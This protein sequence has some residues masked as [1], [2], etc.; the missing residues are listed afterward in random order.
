VTSILLPPGNFDAFRTPAP[1]GGEGGPAKPPPLTHLLADSPFRP[2]NWRWEKARALQAA[3]RRPDRRYDDAHIA[4]ALAFLG[5]RAK[6]GDEWAELEFLRRHEPVYLAARY[7]A[8]AD[9][10]DRVVRDALE[11]RLLAAN[12]T[13]EAIAKVLRCPLE[14]VRWYERL[15]FNVRDR[16]EARDWLM[17]YALGPRAHQVND[18]D[19]ALLWKIAALCGGVIVLETFMEIMG[20]H[21]LEDEALVDRY[22]RD[23]ARDLVARR[24]LVAALTIRGRDPYVKLQL[25]EVNAKFVEIEAQGGAAAGGDRVLDGLRMVLEAVSLQRGAPGARPASVLSS[26]VELRLAEQL[27]LPAPA[28]D[29]T[30]EPPGGTTPAFPAPDPEA[31]DP[32]VAAVFPQPRTATLPETTDGQEAADGAVLP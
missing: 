18:S 6:V 27:A 3:A 13:E 29:A 25:M 28:A 10:P 17:A 20:K 22:C 32:R 9:G 26:G 7:Y 21:V 2:V 31:L 30:L 14:A 19:T 5:D 12:T 8:A 23:Q 4:A 1:A 16:F 24:A 15:F 11:A